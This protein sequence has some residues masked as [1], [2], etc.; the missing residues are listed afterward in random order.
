MLHRRVGVSYRTI[1][2]SE[3][4]DF[5]PEN[6]PPEDAGDVDGAVYRFVKKKDPRPADFVSHLE[7]GLRPEMP[8]CLRAG[9]SCSI[10]LEHMKQVKE[11][12][13]YRKRQT[14]AACSMKPEHGKIKQTLKPPHHTLWARRTVLPQLHELFK[15]V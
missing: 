5:F 2:M 7:R 6:C 14:I 10:D 11:S 3:W 4:P 12:V 8:E 13:P 9:L 1:P 15:A